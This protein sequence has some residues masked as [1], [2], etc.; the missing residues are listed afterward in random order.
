MHPVNRVKRFRETMK[1]WHLGAKTVR[2]YKGFC[3]NRCITF[4]D[5]LEFMQNVMELRLYREVLY[6]QLGGI[7]ADMEL[8]WAVLVVKS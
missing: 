6:I 7:W 2:D 5:R 4:L 1:R 3:W 8:Y